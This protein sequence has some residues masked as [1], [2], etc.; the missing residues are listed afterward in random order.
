MEYL[1]I[2]SVPAIATA[3]YWVINIIKFAVKN[4]AFNRFSPLL[5]AGMGAIFGVICFYAV[6]SI[7][8]AENVIVALIIG[9]ASGLTATGANQ[10]V[11]QLEKRDGGD[12]DGKHE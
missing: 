2:I 1:E 12:D 7:V 6:P 10:I 8:P 9:A 4:E 3:V 11:K 5:A